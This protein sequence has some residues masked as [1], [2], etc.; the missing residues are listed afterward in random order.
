MLKFEDVSFSYEKKE[1]L[2]HF[3]FEIS[4]GEILA[5]MGPSGCGKTTVLLLAAGLLKA[6]AGHVLCDTDAIACA[7]QEP[8]LFPWLTAEQNLAAVLPRHSP[9]R[10]E[11]QG[12]LSDLGLSDAKDKYPREL[13]GGMK[14]RVSLAR[15]L[16]SADRLILLDEPFA[17]LDEEL[18][19]KLTAD[20]R[21]RLKKN[22]TAAL[23]VTH[24]KEDAEALADRILLMSPLSTTVPAV[25]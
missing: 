9:K 15:A 19:K 11:I 23:F 21:T 12:L 24:Q 7:F 1:V 5:L 10:S 16:L 3:S 6:T 14:S 13:S 20:L 22:G 17:A 2:S 4:P 8:R 18:R 25:D